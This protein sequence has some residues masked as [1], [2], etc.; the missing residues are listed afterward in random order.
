MELFAPVP[1]GDLLSLVERGIERRF[2]K[3]EILAARDAPGSPGLIV[4][5]EGEAAVMWGGGTTGD[6]LICTLEPGDF[7]GQIEVFEPGPGATFVKAAGTVR[8]IAWRRED[9]LQAVQDC[10]GMASGFLAGM[11]RQQR[12]LQRRLAGVAS[13]RAP[14]RLARTLSALFEDRGIRLKDAEGRRCLLLPQPP[15]QRR[16]GEISGIARETVSRLMGRWELCGWI[17]ESQGDLIVRDEQE[18]RRIADG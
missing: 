18:L 11:A 8:M 6:L 4:I 9:V 13:Q 3:D 17:A 2:G 14:R 5:L 15:T 1:D 16:L 10:P 7:A 12:H